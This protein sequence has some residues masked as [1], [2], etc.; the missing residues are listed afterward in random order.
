MS[1]QRV[2]LAPQLLQTLRSNKQPLSCTNLVE[3]NVRESVTPR[4]QTALL[5]RSDQ[6]G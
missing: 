2:A 3:A 1:T 6:P 4:E 5:D